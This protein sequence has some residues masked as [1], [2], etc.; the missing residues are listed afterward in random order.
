M[1]IAGLIVSYA[2][3]ALLACF[4]AAIVAAFAF[5]GGGTGG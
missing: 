2:Q 1:A 4:V 3:F 5:S